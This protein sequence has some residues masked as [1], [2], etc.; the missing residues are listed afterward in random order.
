MVLVGDPK[1]SIY[2]FRG[3]DIDTYL[4]RARTA[5]TH[6]TLTSNWRSDA[7]LVDALQ[8][9]LGDA[10]LGNP[11]IP[12]RPVSRRHR[13]IP[14]DRCAV[15]RAA[16]VAGD[17]PRRLHDRARNGK[18]PIDRVRQV[19]RP[20][21]H[22]RRRGT[23]R[24]RRRVRRRAGGG[25]R[26]RGHRRHPSAGESGAGEP[27]RRPAF[28]RWSSGNVSVF[29]TKAGDDWL[30]LLEALEQ[31]HRSGRVRAA[32]LTPFVGRTAAE[33]AAGGERLTDELSALFS[34]WATV[35]PPAAWPR[36]SRSAT[37]E[38]DLPAR[39]LGRV[40]GERQLTD[41]RHV[42][43]SLHAA[44]LGEGLG[45]AALTEWLRRRRADQRRGDHHRPD[46]P[47]RHRRRGH[48]GR[49]PAR[50]QGSAVPG[51]VPAVRVRP[52]RPDP[53][54]AAA[55]RRTASGCSTSAG[56]APRAV[57]SGSGRRWP[58]TPVRRC[59]MLYVGSDPGAV[60]GGHLVGADQE[61][62]VLGP[63]PGA[64]RPSGPDRRRP[65]RGAAGRR[66]RRRA[67]SCG[68]S[69]S[70]ADL[71]VEQAAVGCRAAR[72]PAAGAGTSF[73]VGVLDRPVDDRLAPGVVLVVVRRAGSAG[74]RR[75]SGCRGASRRGRRGDAGVGSEPETGPSVQDEA[76]PP[77]ARPPSPADE[78][79]L[80]VP[81]PMADL[82]AGTSFGTLVHAVLETT[83]PQAADLLAELRERSAEQIARRAAPLTPTNSPPRC[84][85]CCTSPLGPL[86]AG[87]T[88]RD[89]PMRDR[90]AEMD[91]EVPAG[92]RRRRWRRG[93]TGITLGELAPVLR[94][95][96]AADDP[97]AGYADRL[98]SPGFA[99]LPL[100]GY[101]TGSLDA[102][103][104]LARPALSGGRLQDQL[105]GRD[106]R[107]RTRIAR[108]ASSVPG[109]A[110][111]DSSRRHWQ[112][113][114]RLCSRAFPPGTTG[115]RRWTR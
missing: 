44:A 57:P 32:A 61:H 59:G 12:V 27:R 106:R 64:V 115:R 11:D 37:T 76:I 79:L 100:R 108:S 1:Q 25:G 30:V 90:L 82:P 83:D 114:Y 53:G 60:A 68:S 97:L 77:A 24:L 109:S 81:S 78:A 92:R 87:I 80:A 8:V 71:V 74:A 26:H 107:R 72:P 88:L 31:P 50:Q 62:P 18:I 111:Q 47:A 17:P 101:L 66:R 55:A 98:A 4:A 99:W 96:L 86:A 89:I 75:R 21:P 39:L 48:A 70:A 104:R 33:L 36:C 110:S 14:A 85:R 102:V 7:P 2:A 56:P 41:L 13:E 29:H 51:G 23:A 54:H 45:L 16:A 42:G 94:R 46:P 22:R 63:A 5:G 91:F 40:D 93:R 28:R 69:S 65:R 34:R 20:R 73:A 15:Q 84:S 103:I 58:R 49:H 52:V 35:L 10:A 67:R 6:A 105:A 113:R 19:H 43:Q 3:G 95:H 38:Q 112:D 9:L